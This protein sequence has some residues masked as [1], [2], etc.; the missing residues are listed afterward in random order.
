MIQIQG[1]QILPQ[2]GIGQ[3]SRNI[4]V[5]TIWE[6]SAIGIQRVK[7]RDAAKHPTVY[8]TALHNK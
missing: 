2:R 5:V 3:M 6:D 1:R 8:K 4:L 7:A